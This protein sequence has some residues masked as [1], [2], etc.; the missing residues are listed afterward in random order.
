MA[1]LLAAAA[2]PLP[3]VAVVNLESEGVILIY[4][5][6]ER[7]VEA[8][9]LLKDHLDVTVLLKPP[10]AIAPARSTEFPIVRGTVRGAK[11][12]VGAF[13]LTVDDFAQPSPS[14]RG[15][16]VFE[17]SRNGAQSQCDIFLDISGGTALFPAADLR[18][19]YLR[20]DPNDPA[21]ILKAVLQARDLVGTFEKPR[22]ITLTTISARIPARASSGA[23]AAWTFAR[24]GPSRR[25]ATT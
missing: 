25:P 1:A 10:A 22:Y 13:E 18:D 21:A 15:T 7:A 14:S 12:H 3:P 16:L 20:A 11:G 9:N 2:E 17:G 24:P 4:G 19:G 23:S 6:D 5:A 8:G